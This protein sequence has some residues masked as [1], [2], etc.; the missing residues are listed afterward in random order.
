MN[1]FHKTAYG[2][3]HNYNPVSAS[4]N[5]RNPIHEQV[6][7]NRVQNQKLE[8]PLEKKIEIEPTLLFT[9][10]NQHKTPGK[11]AEGPVRHTVNRS[12]AK[13]Y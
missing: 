4:H 6:H 10:K 5:R 1:K 12:E 7:H 3:P 2:R 11:T 8:F 13:F 9:Q